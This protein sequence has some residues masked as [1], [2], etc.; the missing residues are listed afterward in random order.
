MSAIDVR[1]GVGECPDRPEGLG[2]VWAGPK[3]SKDESNPCVFCGTSG[4]AFFQKWSASRSL[5]LMDVKLPMDPGTGKPRVLT[6]EQQARADA[7]VVDKKR[8]DAEAVAN[9]TARPGQVAGVK[10]QR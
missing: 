9:G 2:H 10:G 3:A 7:V 1:P 4:R 6:A 8:R 5:A